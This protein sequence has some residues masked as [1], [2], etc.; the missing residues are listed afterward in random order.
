MPKGAIQRKNLNYLSRQ[1]RDK[2]FGT[3][4]IANEVHGTSWATQDEMARTR[5]SLRR[6]ESS[7]EVKRLYTGFEDEWMFEPP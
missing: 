1:P 4:D 6:L 2:W 3:R 5:Q 7:G